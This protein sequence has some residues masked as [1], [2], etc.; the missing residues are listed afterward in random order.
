MIELENHHFAVHNELTDLG[1]VFANNIMRKKTTRHNQ[2]EVHM[3]CSCQ[4][5]K[6]ESD[7]TST[8]T[9]L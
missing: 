1:S 7:P 3:R 8:P 9:N 4:N 5:V 2:V 6:P